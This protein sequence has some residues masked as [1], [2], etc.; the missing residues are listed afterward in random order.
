VG[1][2]KAKSGMDARCGY[3][4]KLAVI[5]ILLHLSP[6]LPQTTGHLTQPTGHQARVVPSPSI[7]LRAH[8]VFALRMHVS[9]VL[10]SRSALVDLMS[11]CG[12]EGTERNASSDN[13]YRQAI[14]TSNTDKQYRQAILRR[15]AWLEFF[16]R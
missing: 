3:W 6:L 12:I 8:P 7:Q 11:R 5:G 9:F 10:C 4:L 1:K 2:G 13:Q 15:S 16:P 14:P